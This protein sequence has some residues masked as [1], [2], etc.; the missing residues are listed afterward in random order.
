M[1]LDQT[2]KLLHNKRNHQQKEK[3][4]VLLYNKYIHTVCSMGENVY[5]SN[6]IR[7]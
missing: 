4:F 1:G 3:S 7:S 2:R 6:L 5:K